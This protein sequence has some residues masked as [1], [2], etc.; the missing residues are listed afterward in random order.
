MNMKVENIYSSDFI[1]EIVQ[2]N[3]NRNLIRYNLFMKFIMNQS[4]YLKEKELALC[5]YEQ[6]K[7]IPPGALAAVFSDPS[8]SYWVY[9]SNCIKKRLENGEDIPISDLPYLKG[10][11]NMKLQSP[12]YFHLIEINRFLFSAAM[13]SRTPLEAPVNFLEGIFYLPILGLYFTSNIATTI[14]DASF[15]N[16]GESFTFRI[17]DQFFNKLER[18]LFLAENGSTKFLQEG[19]AFLQASILG[20]GGKI[21]LDRIDPFIRLEW[22]T[23]YRNP[24]GSGYSFLE[25]SEINNEVQIANNAFKLIE[26]YWFEMSNHISSTIRSIHLVKSPYP[27]RHMSC[28]SELFFGSILT[29]TGNEFQL[30]EAM[31]HEYSHN[32]LNMVILSGEIFEGQVPLEE[33]YYS[34]WRD[35]PRHISGILHAV[36]VFI[37]VSEL[38]DRL[39]NANSDNIYLNARKLENFIRLDMGLMV[40]KTFPFQ[41]DFAKTLILELEIKIEYLKISYEKYDLATSKQNQVMHLKNWVENHGQQNCPKSLLEYLN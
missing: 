14:T 3:V 41:K 29:S 35:D 8:F 1:D 37:N 4:Q 22:S 7:K 10:L 30:A 11:E 31:V 39:S 28:T 18:L 13:L 34:P 26:E 19:N 40:L 32:L 27:D 16:Q 12:L 20:P 24:D 5:I 9:L 38:L 17:G 36:F 2:Q 25:F 21:I 15:N 23:L 6:S 33:I